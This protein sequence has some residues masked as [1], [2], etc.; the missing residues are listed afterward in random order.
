MR[1]LARILLQRR[2]SLR[3]FARSAVFRYTASKVMV[4]GQTDRGDMQT[5]EVFEQCIR[6]ASELEGRE[7]ELDLAEKMGT[8][9]DASD[10]DLL[11]IQKLKGAIEFVKGRS[12]ASDQSQLLY[13][14][15]QYANAIGKPRYAISLCYIVINHPATND[16]FHHLA[17][18]LLI[19]IKLKLPADIYA[20][21]L[22]N[23]TLNIEAALN[24]SHGW[25]TNQ[26]KHASQP[27][28]KHVFNADLLK[29]YQNKDSEN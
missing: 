1:C 7:S 13:H 2:Q 20:D 24:D 27:P 5:K 4:V 16:K 17:K 15:A 12:N 8:P 11:V 26:E 9:L 23:T 10:F 25:L 29:K 19:E 21:E 18:D 6:F 14:I 28:T 3:N 22:Q